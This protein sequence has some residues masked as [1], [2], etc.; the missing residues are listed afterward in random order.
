MQ[1]TEAAAIA[2]AR[3][4]DGEAFRLLVEKH[5]RSVFRLGFRLTG[6]AQDA[7]DV[8][9]EA[10]LRAYRQ[11]D[12]YDGRASFHTWIYRIASNYALDL[13]RGRKRVEQR[14][15]ENQISI[16]DT[17]PSDDPAA[18]RLV[19]STQVRQRLAEAM[20]ELSEQERTAFVLRHY[21]GLSIDQIG[22]ALGIAESA[23][24]NSIFRAVQ[25][26]RRALEPVMGAS[27]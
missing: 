2:K 9:Q 14:K 6:N 11:L 7:E 27:R 25:K 23:T 16:V 1:E 13:L 26:L 12:R 17:V 20:D 5:S 10:F 8:V 15:D 22:E 21:E 19:Y 3:T 18:D 24:K 4:G